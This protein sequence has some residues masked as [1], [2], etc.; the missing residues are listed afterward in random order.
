MATEQKP[1]SAAAVRR[2]VRR[3]SGN[4]CANCGLPHTPGKTNHFGSLQVYRRTPE[5][6]YTIQDCVLWCRKCRDESYA[7]FPPKRRRP[8]AA[9]LPAGV[10]PE[11]SKLVAGVEGYRVDVFGNVWSCWRQ[12]HQAPRA[13]SDRWRKLNTSSNAAGHLILNFAGLDGVR[14]HAF[15][16]VLVLEAFIGPRPE[17][18]PCCR[19]LNDDKKDNRLENLCWGTYA[20]NAADRIRNGIFTRGERASR[21]RFTEADIKAMRSRCANGEMQRDVAKDFNTAPSV[22]SQIVNRL[23]WSHV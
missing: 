5:S 1:L 2:A 21:A 13:M 22:V 12:R 10:I 15:V 23:R 18:M 3:L 17:S 6:P 19:H 16:H 20:E 9:P 11:N 7:S 14:R 8:R 4:R